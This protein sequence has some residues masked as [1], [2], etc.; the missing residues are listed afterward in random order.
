L[1]DKDEMINILKIQQDKML[2][3]AIKL[4]NKYKNYKAKVKNTIRAI[5]EQSEEKRRELEKIHLNS[6]KQRLGE[7]T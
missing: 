2:E 5:I 4:E 1:K 7:I 6:Q 3:N